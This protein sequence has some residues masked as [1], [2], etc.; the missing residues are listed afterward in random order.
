M[1]MM[2]GTTSTMIYD[3]LETLTIGEQVDKLS[4]L[5]VQLRDGQ[6]DHQCGCSD[7]YLFEARCRAQSLADV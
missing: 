3:H 7:L 4:E 5:A 2:T 1:Y 6:S